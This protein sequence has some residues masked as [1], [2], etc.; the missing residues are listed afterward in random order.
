MKK[1]NFL[2][3]FLLYC[4]SSFSV[5]IYV[6][7]DG[8][9]SNPGTSKAPFASINA[10]KAYARTLR[11]KPLTE[12][13]EIIVAPGIYNFTQ[14]LE[15]T[16]EDSGTSLSPLVIRG[17]SGARTILTGGIQLPI[18]QQ[19]GEGLWKVDVGDL[20]KYGGGL[21]QLF[22]NGQ[23]AVCARTPNEGQD[24]KLLR[25]S[26]SDTSADKKTAVQKIRLSGEQLNQLPS[27][28]SLQDVVISINHAWDRTKKYIQRLS[29]TDSSV[30]IKGK[31]MQSWNK[32]DN[33]A[34]FYFENAKE[35]LDA[36]GE[37]FLNSSGILFYVPRDGERIETSR[38]IVPTI[39]K[40]L[41]LKG[42]ADKKVENIQF[43]DLS[44]RTT[45]YLMPSAGEE[46][47]QAAAPTEAAVMLD[48]VSQVNFDNCEISHVANNA[49]WF[50]AG[51]KDSK[52]TTC[53]MHDL[54]IGG[55]KIGEMSSPAEENRATGNI[56]I[57]N[58]IIRS[59]GHVIPTGVG[60]LI[61]QSGDNTVSHNEIADFKYSGVSVGWVWG[62]GNSP[63]KRNKILFN[64]IHHL[65]WGALSDMGGVYTLG[66]SEGTVVSNNVIHD[67]YSYG[68]GGWGLYTDEGSTGIVEENNLV[69]NCKS[70][71]FHQH[72]GKDNIIRNNIFANQ[73]K[74]QLQASRVEPHHSF[75]FSNNIVYWNTGK[76]GENNWG[77]VNATLD[78]N[79]YWDTR[80]P[81]MKMDAEKNSIVEDPGFADPSLYDF[82]L[83][84]KKA[85]AKIGFKPFD[86]KQAGVYG[87][88][89]WKKLA[90]FDP[91]LEVRFAEMVDQKLKEGG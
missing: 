39:D 18:F 31:P 48:Y 51:C 81:A 44:F 87:S 64:H 83:K 14:P 22:V 33:S 12:P 46:P 62:Y 2:L 54:G 58:N 5:T 75:Q 10:A 78:S 88:G 85:M 36:P 16:S 82:R 15:F 37:F 42:T 21:Q 89:S 8:K 45:N 38:A 28:S 23:R 26:E 35:F 49:I 67:I 53:Y 3:I 29:V 71:G 1:F 13:V 57:D 61:F 65:G 55:V 24:Y 60:V 34:Q 32:L 56:T 90:E 84:N 6:S 59:G 17:K 52:M 19:A 68:Y 63:A 66:P 74:A 72:Y 50:R 7:P 47:A 25:V 70:S 40:I 91:A 20:A 27:G 77:K 69:Y 79:L 9:D 73:I 4:T 43:K 41:V 86:Y 11:K 80:N 76:L 30:F